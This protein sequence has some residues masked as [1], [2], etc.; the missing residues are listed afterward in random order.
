LRAQ[1]GIATE[2]SIRELIDK[3]ENVIKEHV[4]TDVYA[5]G[6]DRD[7]YYAGSGEPTGQLRDSIKVNVVQEGL[8][9]YFDVIN[10]PT[11]MKSDPNTFLHG[12][13]YY[14]P[15]DI[16]GFIGKLINNGDTGGLFGAKWEG[17]K[18]PFLTNADEELKRKIPL[19]WNEILRRNLK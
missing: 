4:D 19:W 1:L 7:F 14:S 12:S 8:S 3:I 2:K 16:S 15:N 10:D 6:S 11:I 13:N 18:R 17:L 9:V 5:A